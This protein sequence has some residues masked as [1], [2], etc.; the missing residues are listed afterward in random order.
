MPNLPSND[1]KAILWVEARLDDWAADPAAIGL[2]PAEVADLDARAA[3][4]RQRL[5]A[6]EEAR[7]TARSATLAFHQAS[8]S[9]KGLASTLIAAVKNHAEA[10][11]DPRVYVAA[12]VEPPR[13]RGPRPAPAMPESLRTRVAGG[14]VELSWKARGNERAYYVVFRRLDGDERFAPL[15]DTSAKRFTD[16]GIPPGTTGASYHVVAKRSGR[17][18]PPSLTVR[19]PFHSTP[20]IP[21]A[22]ARPVLAA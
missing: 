13:P 18:S 22:D 10:A 5:L 7:E 15:G 8:A 4:A 2:T 19:V 1:R 9:M 16:D 12:H 6:A 3:E 14:R 11:A 20:T 17:A 21:S